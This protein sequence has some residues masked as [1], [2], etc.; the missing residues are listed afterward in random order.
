MPLIQRYI[1]YITRDLCSL[2]CERLSRPRESTPFDSVKPFLCVYFVQFDKHLF[3]HLY[4]IIVLEY[5][6]YRYS[7]FFV[8]I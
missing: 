5:K 4:R 8:R 2:S 7:I 6:L 3:A 1:T